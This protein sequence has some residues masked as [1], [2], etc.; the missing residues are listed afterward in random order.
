MNDTQAAQIIKF[1]S[2]FP[3]LPPDFE[4]I[5]EIQIQELG[6]FSGSNALLPNG[7]NL[8]SVKRTIIGAETHIMRSN[9]MLLCRRDTNDPELR[10]MTAAFLERLVNWI[11][12][13]QVKRNTAQ[14]HPD[15]PRFG[16]DKHREVIS[17]DGGDLQAQY[18][19]SQGDFAVQI[20]ADYALMFDRNG[21]PIT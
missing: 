20:H 3:N 4:Q 14:K 19:N 13:E 16:V 21:N 6:T 18:E 7:I 15:L 8:V 12:N 10:L 9:F 2:A 17:A 1:L 5:T 11:N